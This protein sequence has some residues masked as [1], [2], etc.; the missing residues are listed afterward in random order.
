MEAD[1]KPKR[2]G[3]KASDNGVCINLKYV[4]GRT[5]RKKRLP[6]VCEYGYHYCMDI[7]DVLLYY[8]YQKGVTKLF[9]IED[10]GD[11]LVSGNKTVTNAIKIVRE[12]PFNEWNTLMKRTIF[13]ENQNII[14]QEKEN[15]SWIE[16]KYNS[17]GRKILQE[18]SDGYWIEW[19]YN[20]YGNM[21]TEKDSRGYWKRWDFDD[22]GRKTREENSCGFWETYKYDSTG[23]LIRHNNYPKT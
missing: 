19:T 21:T 23:N 16:W 2:I 12:I 1:I 15:C 14:R 18:Q 10:F 11:F 13:D 4:V 22:A 3:Y 7:D 20:S 5:Y 6:K 9:E 17:D 8:T